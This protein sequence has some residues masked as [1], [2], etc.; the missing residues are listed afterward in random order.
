MSP[1]L[2]HLAGRIDALSLRERVFLFVALAVM[3]LALADQLVISVDLQQQKAW[4]AQVARESDELKA[5]RETLMRQGGAAP[6]TAP[7]QG[8]AESPVDTLRRALALAEAERDALRRRVASG[9]DAAHPGVSA[10]ALPE[11]LA[12]VVRRHGRVTLL[13]LAT[14]TPPLAA[15]AGGPASVPWQGA[16]LSL[17]GG[18]ADL[19]QFIAELESALP[20][21]RWGT[22]Q[23]ETDGPSPV[24]TAQVWLRGDTP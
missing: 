23:L 9:G 3:L 16:S 14:G 7:A 2:N 8:S 17:A 19:Q 12:Q 13:R 21:L 22:L 18:Y 1:A 10:A 5:L 24:I 20:G 6:G 11:L 15:G 4:G